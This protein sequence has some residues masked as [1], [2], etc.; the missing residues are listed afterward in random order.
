MT[1]EGKNKRLFII[2]FV[3]QLMKKTPTHEYF[4]L[5]AML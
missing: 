1:S 2:H 3:K 4:A 5:H